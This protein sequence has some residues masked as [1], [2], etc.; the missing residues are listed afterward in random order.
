MDPDILA[1]K[2]RA[3]NAWLSYGDGST[4]VLDVRHVFT[5][6]GCAFCEAQ[7]RIRSGELSGRELHGRR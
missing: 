7:D 2:A 6:R 3:I 5:T 4:Y 1:V